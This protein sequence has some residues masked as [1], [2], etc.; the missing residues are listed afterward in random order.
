MYAGRHAQEGR[1]EY[2]GTE[3]AGGDGS[4]ED[5]VFHDGNYGRGRDVDENYGIRK[6]ARGRPG[7]GNDDRDSRRSSSSRPTYEDENEEDRADS[8]A[9]R[10][11]E[12]GDNRA[13]PGR[14]SHGNGWVGDAE[15][16][17][18]EFDRPNQGSNR[19]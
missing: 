17:R 13:S 16:G 4:D 2:R 6:D 12:D 7:K 8:T 5:R 1:N 19:R 9:G 18:D 10:G 15:R 14:R 3:A 11:D